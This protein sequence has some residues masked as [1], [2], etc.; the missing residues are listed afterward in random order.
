MTSRIPKVLEATEESNAVCIGGGFFIVKTQAGFRKVLKHYDWK[1]GDT[2]A[3][4]CFPTDYPSVITVTPTGPS[5][6]WYH[7]NVMDIATLKSNIDKITGVPNG[8]I[9]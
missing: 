4:S 7:V 8:D 1:E 9:S 3:G 6:M 2:L 5:N